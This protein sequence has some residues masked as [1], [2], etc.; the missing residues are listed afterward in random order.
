MEEKQ[1]S[2]GEKIIETKKK[3]ARK[4]SIVE[5]GA[6]SVSDGFG[7]RN[8]APYALALNASNSMIGLLTSIPSLF[9]NLFQLLT[10]KL[11]RKY[12]RKKVVVFTVFLQTFFWLALL[13]PGILFLKSNSS[14]NIPIILLISIYTFLIISGALAGPAWSSWMKDIV[15]EK[16]LGTYFAK[17]NK[18]AGTIVFICMIL[19][20]LILDYFKR[21]EVL[22]G[23]FIL[24]F[25]SFLF[26][27]ISG[28][29]FTK[30]YEPKFKQNKKAYFSLRSFINNM[31]FNNFGR[32]VLFICTLN[33]FVAIAS[34]FFAVY[35]L[36]NKGFSYTLYMILIMLMPLASILTMSFWGKKSDTIGNT[37]IFKMTGLLIALIP[38][39]YLL[40]NFSNKVLTIFLILL[41]IEILAGIGWGGFNLSAANFV[42]K[43]VSRDKMVICS[44]YMNALNGFSIFLGATM[45]GLLAS[46]Q[47]WNP[48][49]LVFLIS[50]IGRLLVYF[51]IRPK[52]KEKTKKNSKYN[53]KDFISIVSLS[54]R[55]LHSMSD[56]IYFK[57]T[58]ENL[59]KPKWFKLN[60]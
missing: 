7:L 45:G 49:L 12:S 4:L 43:S 52:I 54:P 1:I 55:F 48:I 14:S 19:A 5:A 11:V 27:G 59:K 39:I 17:R 47:F 24:L 51:L 56:V 3:K 32:F 31:F 40:S 2:R 10:H 8:I 21:I 20:G 13:L 50:G 35:L 57:K 22:Y 34:P 36:R 23:F 58:W 28:Y 29:L 25:F 18:I 16:Q 38:F 60:Q 46:I 42:L 41:P 53:K 9:G 15:P 30:K 26:R 44:S 33:F 37:K 6:F